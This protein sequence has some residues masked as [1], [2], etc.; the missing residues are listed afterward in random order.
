MSYWSVNKMR[1]VLSY[2]FRGINIITNLK[3]YS[4]EHVFQ[5]PRQMRRH[6]GV[7]RWISIIGTFWNKIFRI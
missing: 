4:K 2:L 6:S 7:N 3:F 5:D 1:H